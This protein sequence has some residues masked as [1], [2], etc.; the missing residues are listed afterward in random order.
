MLDCAKCHRASGKRACPLKS[1]QRI[2]ARCCQLHQLNYSDCPATCSFLKPAA[3]RAQPVA[4]VPSTPADLQRYLESAPTRIK[5]RYGTIARHEVDDN[6]DVMQN[7]EAGIVYAADRDERISDAEVMQALRALMVI[8]EAEEPGQIPVLPPLAEPVQAVVDQ[9]QK[10]VRM[11]A[12]QAF[13]IPLP[14]LLPCLYRILDSVT[15]WN[16]R[17]GRRG[18]LDFVW[19]RVGVRH[20]GSDEPLRM[21]GYGPDTYREWT[22]EE[23]AHHLTDR[24]SNL[25]K[26][27]RLVEATQVL[28]Q[29][30]RLEPDNASIAINLSVAYIRSARPDG[31]IQLLESVKPNRSDDYTAL[32][33]NLGGAYLFA[34]RE[35]EAFATLQR[36]ADLNPQIAGAPTFFQLGRMYYERGDVKKALLYLRRG[37]K[38]DPDMHEIR[39]LIEEIES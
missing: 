12:E 21:T 27:G 13:A 37:Q 31:A 35:D 4:V 33:V 26:A 11:R 22:P 24:G 34:G 9:V 18:Y 32:M 36:V 39:E 6:L 30:H 16:K 5:R 2:C 3:G 25:L 29:A 19:D 1:G 28:E 20:D 7:L 8:Y 15:L 14:V 38:M 10:V 17:E 23:Q